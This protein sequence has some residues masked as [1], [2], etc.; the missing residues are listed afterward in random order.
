ME[1]IRAMRNVK[2]TVRLG[3]RDGYF[4]KCELFCMEGKAVLIFFGNE[5]VLPVDPVGFCRAEFY[6]KD[7]LEVLASNRSKQLTVSITNKTIGFNAV[8]LTAEVKSLEANVKEVP[9]NLLKERVKPADPYEPIAWKDYYTEDKTRGFYTFEVKKD[10][11]VVKGILSKYKIA[12]EEVEK[13]IYTFLRT[14]L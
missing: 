6:L 8:N 10:V 1:M 9:L 3:S 2:R 7:A 13:F 12:S 14:S 4:F 11:E 5:V